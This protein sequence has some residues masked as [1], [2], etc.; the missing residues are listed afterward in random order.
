MNPCF[1]SCLTDNIN[2][3]DDDKSHK[4]SELKSSAT[5]DVSN[6]PSNN[7]TNSN[8]THLQLNGDVNAYNNLIKNGFGGHSITDLANDNDDHQNQLQ[9]NEKIPMEGFKRLYTESDIELRHKIKQITK[10]I[11][12]IK[13]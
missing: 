7:S 12:H 8:D 13:N 6:K 3:D 9:L 11:N 5:L 2:Q 1:N 4:S 10:M